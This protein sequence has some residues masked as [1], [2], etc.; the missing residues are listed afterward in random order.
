MS[1]HQK[2]QQG[3][4]QSFLEQLNDDELNALAAA[5][6]SELDTRNFEANLR[7]ELASH[8]RQYR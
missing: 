3:E 5:V 1:E 8:S 2:Q 4:R 7:R 6:D